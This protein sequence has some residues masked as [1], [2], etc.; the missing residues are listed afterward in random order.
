MFFFSFLSMR[1]SKSCA[2]GH[3]V[4]ELTRVNSVFFIAFFN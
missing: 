3:G 4:N 2:H 1:L